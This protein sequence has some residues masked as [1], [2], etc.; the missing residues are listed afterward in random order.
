MPVTRQ[1]PWGFH[2]YDRKPLVRSLS[3]LMH[4]ITLSLPIDKRIDGLMIGF[5]ANLPDMVKPFQLF[6]SNP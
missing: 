4:R 3:T 1:W 5:Q 2:L 6:I